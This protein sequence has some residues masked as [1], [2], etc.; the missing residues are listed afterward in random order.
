MWTVSLINKISPEDRLQLSKWGTELLFQTR[1]VSI[2]ASVPRRAMHNGGE[3]ASATVT[4][5][6]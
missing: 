6:S 2:S 3:A 5:F 4:Y 1:E